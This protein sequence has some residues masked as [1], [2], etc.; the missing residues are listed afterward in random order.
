[1]LRR[2]LLLLA[3]LLLSACGGS[4]AATASVTIASTQTAPVIVATPT[5]TIAASTPTSVPTTAPPT[6]TADRGVA[7]IAAA[8]G[9]NVRNVPGTTGSTIMVALPHG[10]TVHILGATPD[11]TWYHITTDGGIT[12]WI[13]AP[14]ISIDANAAPVPVETTTAIVPAVGQSFQPPVALRTN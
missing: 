6:A 12:G 8:K 1:M 3:A 7:H 2:C 4:T 11:H 10:A 14:L 13:S 9:A 5:R